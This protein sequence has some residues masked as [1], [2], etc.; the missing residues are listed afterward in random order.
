MYVYN[1]VLNVE[2]LVSQTLVMGVNES[3]TF[4]LTVHHDAFIPKLFGW[5]AYTAD[6]LPC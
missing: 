5:F 3:L 6:L 1:L 4:F 2:T